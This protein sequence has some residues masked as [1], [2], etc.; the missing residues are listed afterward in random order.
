MN[1]LFEKIK[2]SISDPVIR[3][4]YLDRL[5]FYKRLSDEKYLKKKFFFINGL[6]IEFG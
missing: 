2:W 4:G 5:G 3:S 6:S 1:S